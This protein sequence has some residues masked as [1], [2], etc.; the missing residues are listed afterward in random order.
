MT[1]T[2][3]SLEIDILTTTTR[4]CDDDR[5]GNE[6]DSYEHTLC[7]SSFARCNESSVP[8]SRRPVTFA[9]DVENV[10]FA[11]TTLHFQVNLWTRCHAA[12]YTP[13]GCRRF[14]DFLKTLLYP[15]L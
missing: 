10:A 4:T 15:G 9:E 8:I 3:V 12:G 6:E 7:P 5:K 14:P 1:A 13:D 2:R 11:F